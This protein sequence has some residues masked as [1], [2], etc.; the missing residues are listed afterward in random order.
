MREG[1]FFSLSLNFMG[2]II[3]LNKKIE[4]MDCDDPLVSQRF[5]QCILELVKKYQS[6]R[7]AAQ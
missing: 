7:V 6:C 1:T 3:G 2:L 4:Q 5:A